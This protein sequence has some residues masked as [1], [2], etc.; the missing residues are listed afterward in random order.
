MKCIIPCAGYATRLYPLTLKTPKALLQISKKPIIEHIIGK[1]KE[2]KEINEI[3]IVSNEKFFNIF[4]EWKDSF[5]SDIKITII[6]DKTKSNSDRLGQIG[7]IYFAIREREINEPILTIAGDNLFTFSLKDIYKYSKDKNI[8]NALFDVKSVAESRKLG[9]VE[10]NSQNHFIHFIEKPENP[11]STLCSLGIM[12][13]SKK[14]IDLIKKYI[15]EGHNSD[16]MGYFFQAYYKTQPIHGYVF[17]K[18]QDRWFDIGTIDQ[19]EQVK[20][21][22]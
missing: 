14:A 7:D 9:V 20:D 17:D 15:Q 4:N 22:I 5:K 2:I 18:K 13:F 12:F 8:V 11:K 6:N 10:I 1:I 16:K 3:I 21:G 19:Y